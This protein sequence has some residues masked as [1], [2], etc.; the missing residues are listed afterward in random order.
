MIVV[1]DTSPI[2]YL[3]LIG[4]IGELPKLYQKVVIPKAVFEELQAE[5]TPK[6]VRNWLSDAPDWL[7]VEHATNIAGADLDELDRGEREAIL[8]AEKLKADALIID[9]R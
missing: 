4:E 8:L 9:D 7:T 5:E 6:D 2:N 3:V 1:A